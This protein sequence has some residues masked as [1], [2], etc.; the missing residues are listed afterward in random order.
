MDG[1]KAVSAEVTL[2]A[3]LDVHRVSPGQLAIKDEWQTLTGLPAGSSVLRA[4]SAGG[5]G[6]AGG[7]SAGGAGGVSGFGAS[8]RP[9]ML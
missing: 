4:Y 9:L 1:K 7:T 6:G 2:L 3:S 8:I 5:A